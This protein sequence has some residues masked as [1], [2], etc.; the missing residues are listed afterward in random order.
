MS[1]VTLL[2]AALRMKLC[3]LMGPVPVGQPMSLDRPS[4]PAVEDPAGDLRVKVQEAIAEL[5]SRCPTVPPAAP[6]TRPEHATPT[7]TALQQRIRAQSETERALRRELAEA[8]SDRDREGREAVDKDRCGR[9]SV[10]LSPGLTTVLRL[11]QAIHRDID[12]LK[13]TVAQVQQGFQ[14][15]RAELLLSRAAHGELLK[16]AQQLRAEGARREKSLAASRRATEDSDAKGLQLSARLNE[17][18]CRL[19]TLQCEAEALRQE[20]RAREGRAQEAQRLYVELHT[21]VA[22]TRSRYEAAQSL[23]GEQRLEM[24]RLVAEHGALLQMYAPLA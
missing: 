1:D 3:A 21:R 4:S 22:E 5:Q 17:T 8:A 15:T 14:Q 11:L 2:A 9:L 20:G 6:S 18:Q 13:A 10:P 16:A 19:S 7:V 24:E 23:L 12:L